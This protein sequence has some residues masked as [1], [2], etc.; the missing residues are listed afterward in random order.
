MSLALKYRPRTFDDVIGQK[1]AVETLSKQCESGTVSNGI[2]LCGPAGT[3]K[4]TIARIVATIL[5]AEVHEIDAASN[6]GVEYIRAMQEQANRRSMTHEKKVFIIDECH[7]LSSASWQAMLK[8]LEEPPANSYFILCT[9]ETDKIPKTIMSRV[10][11]FHF[12]PL[13]EKEIIDRLAFVCSCEHFTYENDALKFIAARAGGCMRD[14][15]SMLDVCAAYSDNNITERNCIDSLNEIAP[16]YITDFIKNMV[17]KFC[18]ASLRIFD[19]A[20]NSGMSEKQFLTL[21]LSEIVEMCKSRL[22]KDESVDDLAP[23]MSWLIKTKNEV[24]DTDCKQA[25]AEAKILLW[26][27]KELDYDE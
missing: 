26:C 24:R 15:L 6:N 1:T 18:N 21:C 5:D 23:L 4:T 8:L 13:T 3:G 20:V 9:T 16:V 25:Y 10:Q 7:A 14:A 11:R 19:D 22:L 17:D 27:N 2:L 12:S